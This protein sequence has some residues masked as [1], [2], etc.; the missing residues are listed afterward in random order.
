MFDNI[1]ENNTI[2]FAV[3]A[4]F[5][6]IMWALIWGSDN[7]SLVKL[8]DKENAISEWPKCVTDEYW[9]TTCEE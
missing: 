6:L 2:F 8:N 1:K 4:V 3:L 7:S 5:L 9:Y